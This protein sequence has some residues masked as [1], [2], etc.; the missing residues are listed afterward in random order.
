MWV[1]VVLFDIFSAKAVLFSVIIVPLVGG[2]PGVT[3]QVQT[4]KVHNKPDIYMIDTPGIFLP[5]IE[6]PEVGLKMALCGIW[7]RVS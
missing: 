6:D 4:T 2:I 1:K 5:S 3:K 7:I